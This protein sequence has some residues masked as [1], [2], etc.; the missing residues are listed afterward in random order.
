M[1]D[2]SSYLFQLVLQLNCTNVQ[3]YELVSGK[4]N[5]T[6]S[7]QCP[8]GARTSVVPLGIVQP[9]FYSAKRLV[10]SDKRMVCVQAGSCKA[11]A[12]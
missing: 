12:Q 9:V 4:R 6:Y 3:V 5:A 7:P 10:L 2:R 8:A 1:I 11:R